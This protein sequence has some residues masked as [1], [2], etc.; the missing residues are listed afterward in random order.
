MMAIRMKP[1]GVE[2]IVVYPFVAMASLSWARPAM[3]PPTTMMDVEITV[4][5]RDVAMVSSMWGLRHATME[6]RSTPMDVAQIVCC[7]PV[8]MVSCSPAKNVTIRIS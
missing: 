8:V 6:I 7:L 5:K 1:M 2:M 4:P 3:T